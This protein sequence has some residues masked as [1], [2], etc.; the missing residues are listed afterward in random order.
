[1]QILLIDY[2]FTRS[3]YFRELFVKDM[4]PFFDLGIGIENDKY[5]LNEGG[6]GVGGG[7]MNM[8]KIN[9]LQATS[10]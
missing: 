4:K 7:E 3:K 10:E 9:R 8:N 2:I 6:G 1:M 5:V